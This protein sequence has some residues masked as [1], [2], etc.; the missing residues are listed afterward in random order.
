MRR[1]SRLELIIEV[2]ELCVYPGLPLT[3]LGLKS[4]VS[5][6]KLSDILMELVTGDLLSVETRSRSFSGH[7]RETD[8]YI[9]TSEG[10]ELIRDFTG[11]KERLPRPGA[12]TRSELPRQTA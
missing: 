8:F 12:Q 7:N 4:R 3:R 5:T 1:R 2:I 6:D 9:R 10:D 11:V